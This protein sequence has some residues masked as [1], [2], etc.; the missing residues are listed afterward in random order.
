RLRPAASA[1]ALL[2]STGRKGPDYNDARLQLSRLRLIITPGPDWEEMNKNRDVIPADFVHHFNLDDERD[3]T[4]Q[5]GPDDRMTLRNLI[6]GATYRF[7]GHE[8]IPEP[9]QTVDLG[10]VVVEGRRR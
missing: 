8:L 2:K 1:S 7:R 9:G 5:P 4:P 6:P 10:E 3:N